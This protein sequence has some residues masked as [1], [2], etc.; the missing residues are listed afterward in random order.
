MS[1][2]DDEFANVPVSNSGFSFGNAGDDDD[3]FGD[4]QG[5]DLEI[6][7]STQADGSTVGSTIP[8]DD[9]FLPP[10]VRGGVQDFPVPADDDHVSSGEQLSQNSEETSRASHALFDDAFGSSPP[11]S[12]IRTSTSATAT[13][14]PSAPFTMND[15]DQDFFAFNRL[16]PV[17]E[18]V[19]D[20][21]L[22]GANSSN[23]S[24]ALSLL[25]RS[26][27]KVSVEDL[28]GDVAS[29]EPAPSEGAGAHPS[30]DRIDAAPPGEEKRVTS[31]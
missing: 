31:D 8:E 25:E 24:N 10:P 30:S 7:V 22:E 9:P 19:D 6:T 17:P 28:P 26:F 5:V 14:E 18:D 12:P 20:L 3:D 21:D 11:R 16:R 2:D 23:V 15:V 13:N 4:F 1:F 27:G 29:P